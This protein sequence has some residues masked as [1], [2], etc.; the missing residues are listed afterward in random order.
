MDP[1]SH[2]QVQLYDS[3]FFFSSSSLFLIP[4]AMHPDF[5]PGSP[6]SLSVDLECRSFGC[7]RFAVLDCNK[8]NH[9]SSGPKVRS[10]LVWG[11]RIRKSVNFFRMSF[12]LCRCR[13][14]SLYSSV[15]IIQNHWFIWAVHCE[16]SSKIERYRF[17]WVL[18][19]HRVLTLQWKSICPSTQNTILNYKAKPTN[20]NI[21]IFFHKKLNSNW[22]IAFFL[23]R[24]SL[25]NK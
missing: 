2:Y 7:C 21:S 12:K 1:F 20:L 8:L 23:F 9:H 24:L 11:L 16:N 3:L 15:E 10:C 18:C 17:N 19:T 5:C 22:I 25:L 14:Y 4:S 6:F 13:N